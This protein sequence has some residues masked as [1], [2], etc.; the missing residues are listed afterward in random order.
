MSD[1]VKTNPVSFRLSDEDLEK[2]EILSNSYDIPKSTMATNIIEN[3]LNENM[4]EFEVNHISYPRPVIK[5]LFSELTEK[6]IILMIVNTNAYNKGLIESARRYCSP[7]KILNGLKKNWKSYGCEIRTTRVEDMTVLEI[8]HELEKNWSKI[9][10]ATTSFILELLD[11]KIKNTFVTE[12]W[13][14]IGYTRI[15]DDLS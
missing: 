1:K 15:S 12:D 6:Q 10:S 5:K 8:H 14:K 11:Y 2:L 13:F 4:Q 7:G 9:T 3:V